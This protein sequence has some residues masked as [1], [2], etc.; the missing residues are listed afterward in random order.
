MKHHEPPNP[1]ELEEIQ[2][3]NLL[4]LIYLRSAASEGGSCLGMPP[5]S[6][7]K[8]RNLSS[9]AL[10][11]MA[12]FPRS[13]FIL[14]LENLAA[15]GDHPVLP[16]TPLAQSRQA[17]CLTILHSAWNMC[18]QRDFQARM[19]LRLSVVM[20]RRLRTMPLSEL[21]LLSAVPNVLGC[22][23]PDAEPLWDALLDRRQANMSRAL[24]LIALHPDAEHTPAR[25][26][27]AL[28][29]I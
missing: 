23:S 22:A 9:A 18:R 14:D 3:L 4:F 21:L 29:S 11:A 20:S 15:T 6:V 16:S 13:L 28:H 26:V 8:L 27:F 5:R 2:E 17:L 12:V 7:A 10:E 25:R 1:E 24:R 19:F